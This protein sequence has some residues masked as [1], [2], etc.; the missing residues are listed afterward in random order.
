M[1]ESRQMFTKAAEDW[2]CRSSE[3][4]RLRYNLIYFSHPTH[5]EFKDVAF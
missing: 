4:L 3:Q 5:N 2:T 1:S